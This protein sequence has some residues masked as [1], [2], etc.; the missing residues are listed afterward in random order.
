[1]F[2]SR[3]SQM[4]FKTIVI[5]KFVN[6]TEKTCVGVFFNKVAGPQNSNFMQ[7]KFQQIFF[8]VKFVKFLRATCFTSPAAASA[9]LRFPSCNFVKKENPAKMSSCE[10]YR[11]FRNIFS[12]NTSGW[13][14]FVFIWELWEVFQKT[15]FI[16]QLISNFDHQI[17]KETISRVVFKDFMQ[18]RQVPIRKDKSE[19]ILK[20]PENYL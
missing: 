6:F 4:F 12:L 19:K 10:F 2:R 14:L 20:I 8:P 11:I 3:H 9:I 5:K 13:L 16:D 17:Q 1:M 18:E 7:K 15:S